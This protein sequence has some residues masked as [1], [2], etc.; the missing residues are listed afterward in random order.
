MK[1]SEVARSYRFPQRKLTDFSEILRLER[2]QQLAH[3]CETPFIIY[4]GVL[5]VVHHGALLSSLGEVIADPE[6]IQMWNSRA[7][8]VRSVN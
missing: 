6:L 1:E 2:G 7:G 8:I 4:R 5:T 3:G